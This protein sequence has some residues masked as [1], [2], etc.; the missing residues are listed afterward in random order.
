MYAYRK[1]YYMFVYFSGSKWLEDFRFPLLISELLKTSARLLAFSNIYIFVFTE[2]FLRSLC[3]MKRIDDLPAVN[4][5]NLQSNQ[6][7][8]QK[9]PNSCCDEYV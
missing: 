3:W 9:L 8:F 1:S 4:L 5:T 6:N 2:Y 7:K